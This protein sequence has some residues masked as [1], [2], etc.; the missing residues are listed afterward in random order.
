MNVLNASEQYFMVCI[1]Y[2]NW[3]WG[4]GEEEGE[5]EK[6]ERG[7]KSSKISSKLN[8]EPHAAS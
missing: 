8:Y 6:E 4:W 7:I 2:H 3:G 5:R 1:F